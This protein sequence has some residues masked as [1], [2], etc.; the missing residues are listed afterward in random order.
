M[1][2]ILV[3]LLTSFPLAVL[4]VRSFVDLAAVDVQAGFPPLPA[5]WDAPR[6]SAD[7]ARA[8]VKADKPLVQELAQAD[9]F[10][11]QPVPALERLSRNSSLTSLGGSWPQWMYAQRMAGKVIEVEQQA[12]GSDVQQLNDACRQLAKLRADYADLSPRGSQGLLL[13]LERRLAELQAK[14]GQRQVEQ[15]T[16]ETLSRAIAALERKQYDE[17]TRL[18]DQLLAKG[19]ET[20]E[21][22][23][24]SQAQAI[25]ARAQF[26]RAAELLP[27]ELAEAKTLPARAAL[28]RGFLDAHRDREGWTA[29]ETR[30]ADGYLSE[31]R[32][33]EKQVEAIA[34]SQSAKVV[35]ERFRKELPGE[36]SQRLARALEIADRYPQEDVKTQLRGE[37]R[38]GLA[39]FLPEKKIAESPALREMET[40][41]QEI[42]RGFIKEVKIPD[43]TAGYKRYSTYEQYLH[44]DVEVGTYRQ[45]VLLRPPG[46][47]VPRQCVARYDEARRRLL[48][49]P[50]RREAWTQMADLC[51]ALDAALREYRAKPGA[52]TEELS[53]AREEKALR[54]L[55]DAPIW[56]GL[57]KLFG[58]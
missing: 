45:E 26:C 51:Q 39:D 36:L 23:V 12:N 53:F 34:R 56:D 58:P 35:L 15:A 1:K 4:T 16:G 57:R 37:V 21:A 24:R 46:E 33:L 30:I 19:G 20:I 28:L 5:D 9:L 25:R 17:C 42:I 14:I 11:A 54:H 38:R 55:V 3:L 44:P 22:A 41:K 48:E 7:E 2:S 52:S 18:C 32:A 10:A 49:H 8:Q 43:G 40:K 29:E 31:L 6:A 13:I 27:R 47:S 50:Q